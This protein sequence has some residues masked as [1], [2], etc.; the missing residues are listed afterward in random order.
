MGDP[1]GKSILRTKA[2][3]FSRPFALRATFPQ[4]KFRFETQWLAP[5]GLRAFYSSCSP[6]AQ[7]YHQIKKRPDERTVFTS[8]T[9][10]NL[11]L[12]KSTFLAISPQSFSQALRLSYR[13]KRVLASCILLHQNHRPEWLP[14]ELDLQPSDSRIHPV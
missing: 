13:L 5:D 10:K 3:Y 2:C 6:L 8:R 14:I 1:S 7:T 9:S 4:P 11:F 12:K